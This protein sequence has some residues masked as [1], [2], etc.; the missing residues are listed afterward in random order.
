MSNKLKM[1]ILSVLSIILLCIG[2]TS[3]EFQNDTFYT[4]KIGE[5]IQNNGIDMMDHFSW[6]ENLP[7]EYPHWLYDLITYW[8]YSLFS[9]DGIF[10]TT[11]ILSCILGVSIYLVDYKLTKNNVVS[12]FFLISVNYLLIS[13]F[14]SI[15]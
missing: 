2:V 15:V 6:H 9:F 11:A 8:I 4:I 5:L 12:F 14:M 13:Y 7:Y 1:R 10:I 3:K